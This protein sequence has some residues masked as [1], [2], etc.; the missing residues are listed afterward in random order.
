[1]FAADEKVCAGNPM[2]RKHYFVYENDRT[3]DPQY[4]MADTYRNIADDRLNYALGRMWRSEL[5]HPDDCTVLETSVVKKYYDADL[6][7]VESPE[8]IHTCMAFYIMTL[9][10]L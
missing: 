9:P 10:E 7:D 5:K 2:T 4:N 6:S 8:V 1:M 3:L